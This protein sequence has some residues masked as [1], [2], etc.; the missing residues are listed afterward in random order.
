MMCFDFSPDSNLLWENK[1]H[2]VNCSVLFARSHTI[3]SGPDYFVV[4]RNVCFYCQLAPSRECWWLI[5][6]PVQQSLK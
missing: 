3:S 4:D 5:V 2:Y 1:I 6:S